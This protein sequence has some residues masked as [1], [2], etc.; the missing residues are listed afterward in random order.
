[1]VGIFSLAVSGRFLLRVAKDL[2]HGL[3]IISVVGVVC[4]FACAYWIVST[5]TFAS[6]KARALAWILLCAV[7]YYGSTLAVAEERLHLIIFGLLGYSLAHDFRAAPFPARIYRPF[8]I[9][10]L[11]A[12]FDELLQHFLPYRVGDVRDV[13]FG[14]VGTLMGIGIANASTVVPVA[15]KS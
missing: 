14:A 3:P 10:L 15:T 4:V 2:F 6:K 12:G 8:C 13:L 7:A 9:A 11:I 1:M 5:S